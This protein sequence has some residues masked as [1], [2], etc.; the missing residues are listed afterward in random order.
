MGIFKEQRKGFE[1]YKLLITPLEERDEKGEVV[2]GI[3]PLYTIDWYNPRALTDVCLTLEG[4]V[5]F[6]K[7]ALELQGGLSVYKKRRREQKE[8]M[9]KGKKMLDGLNNL[10]DFLKSMRTK[11]P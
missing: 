3:Q 5:V 1:V 7:K 4:S 11:K 10:E 8:A 2:Y 6:L 9:E